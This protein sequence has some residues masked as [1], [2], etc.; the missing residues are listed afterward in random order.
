MNVLHNTF[1]GAIK[2]YKDNVYCKYSLHCMLI[3][4]LLFHR[5]SV[6]TASLYCC[7]AVEERSKRIRIAIS[8]LIINMLIDCNLIKYNSN[9]NNIKKINDFLSMLI[10]RQ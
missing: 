7:I 2:L 6:F 1:D 3:V 9:N 10:S 5:S 4:L 8:K